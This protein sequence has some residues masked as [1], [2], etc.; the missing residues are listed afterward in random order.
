MNGTVD[1]TL[2]LPSGP[3]DIQMQE[4]VRSYGSP[5]KGTQAKIIPEGTLNHNHK[6]QVR[7]L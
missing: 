2:T 4:T 3:T 1:G 6:I 5:S 7:T